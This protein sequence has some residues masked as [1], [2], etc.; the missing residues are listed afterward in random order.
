MT[1]AF[2]AALVVHASQAPAFTPFG[3]SSSGVNRVLFVGG[4]GVGLWSVWI[5]RRRS[6]PETG[7]RN[8]K[9]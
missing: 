3:F 8:S 1:L 4:A 2:A 6:N 9:P 7:S 5:R